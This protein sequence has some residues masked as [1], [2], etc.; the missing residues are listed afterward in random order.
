M[1]ICITNA[2]LHRKARKP[3]TIKDSYRRR[4][5]RFGI[6]TATLVLVCNTILLIY[7]L[8][9]EKHSYSSRDGASILHRGSCKVA[10]RGAV[11]LHLIINILST[12]LLGSSNYAMQ[13]LA[14]PKRDEITQ[15]HSQGR[16]L[17]IGT[18]SWKNIRILPRLRLYIWIMLGLTSVPLHFL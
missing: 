10:R 1:D 13:C 11:V 15:A 9:R 3:S 4:T 5:L 18:S 14:A 2:Y 17:D 12:F 7:G 16:W 8:M 6:F